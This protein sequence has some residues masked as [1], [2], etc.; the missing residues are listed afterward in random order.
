MT[1]TERWFAVQTKTRQAARAEAN[2]RRWGIETLAPKLREVRTSNG[3]TS[4]HVTCLF[5]NYLFARFDAAALLAKVRLTRG[6]QRVVGCG[7]SA[8]PLD[9]A[10]IASIRSRIAEDGF[11]RLPELR[12]GDRV[13]IVDGPLQ[14][15]AGIFERHVDAN[16]RVLILLTTIGCHARVQVVRSAIRKSSQPCE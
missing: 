7:L 1:R 15:L 4:Q 11:V 3:R 9:D 8:T 13:E 12:P 5:P 6:I 2:L 16:T 10:V 14:S